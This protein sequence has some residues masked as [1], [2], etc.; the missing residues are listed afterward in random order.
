MLSSDDDENIIASPAELQVSKIK[1]N[2]S[3][4]ESKSRKDATNHVL[5]TRRRA[6]TRS[7]AVKSPQ[8]T[9]TQASPTS[10]PKKSTSRRRRPQKIANTRSLYA[11]FNSTDHARPYREEPQHERITPE[12]KEDEKKEEEEEDLIED[13]SYDEGFRKLPTRQTAARSVLDRRKRHNA[14][15]RSR[16][17]LTSL[18]KISGASQKF[19][20]PQKDSLRQP[21]NNSL[22]ASSRVDLRPWTERHRPRGLEELMV[23]NKKVADVQN[24]LEKF[25][26]G[27][28]QKV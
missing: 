4:S 9:S 2:K 14:P 26:Q 17:T 22:A 24:W 5:P 20:I 3:G 18:G 10:S 27:Q 28:N 16:A 23:H 6:N 8:P 19:K 7:T 12:A 15:T 13:D 21:S 1:P 11:F 25:R